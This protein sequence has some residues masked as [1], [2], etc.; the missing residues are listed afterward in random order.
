MITQ[1]PEMFENQDAYVIQSNIDVHWCGTG[2]RNFI[3][4]EILTKQKKANYLQRA[5]M[6][7]HSHHHD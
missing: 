7:I 2:S 1:D 3:E 5:P 6:N 4:Q